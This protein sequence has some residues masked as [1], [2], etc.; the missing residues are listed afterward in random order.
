MKRILFFYSLALLFILPDLYAGKINKDQR[1]VEE[2]K[3]THTVTKFFRACQRQKFK[4][5][6]QLTT[7]REREIYYNILKRIKKRN[8]S[9]PAEV[10]KYFSRLK[11]FYVDIVVVDDLGN[12]AI[13]HCIFQ[14]KFYDSKSRDEIRKFREVHYYLEKVDGEWKITFSKLK[15]E[16]YNYKSKSNPKRNRRY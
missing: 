9:V 16:R 1:E 15:S 3:V 4:E 14:F 10:K 11:K 7:G 8:G 13:A 5:A 6:Y 12:R 2:K